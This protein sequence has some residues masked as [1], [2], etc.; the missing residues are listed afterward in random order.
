M[1]KV[2]NKDIIYAVV[3]IET[4]GGRANRDKITEIAIV[5]TNGREII[6][7]YSTLIN[8]ETFIPYEITRLTGIDQSMVADAPKFYEVAKEIVQFTENCLFIAHNVR[9]DYEFIREEFDRLG[10]SFSRNKACT[11]QLSRKSFPGLRSYSLGNLIEHFG[12][13]AKNRH[14]AYDDAKATAEL[15]HLILASGTM[16]ED[17]FSLKTANKEAVL[18]KDW[19]KKKVDAIP[20]DCGVYYFTNENGQIVYVGKSK[21]IRTRIWE[22]FAGINH[23]GLKLQQ[24]VS[25]IHWNLTST[26]LMAL[27]WELIEIKKHRPSLNKVARNS[28]LNVGV[29]EQ[30][31]QNGFLYFEIRKNWSESDPGFLRS[32]ITAARASSYIENVIHKFELC[33]HVSTG[34]KALGQCFDFGIGLCKGVCNGVES[35]EDYNSRAIA[36]IQHIKDALEG[37]WILY[38]VTPNETCIYY[39][40]ESGIFRGF[41]ELSYNEQFNESS[42]LEQ[43][44][45]VDY[46]SDYQKLMKQYF[47]KPWIK[48]IKIRAKDEVEHELISV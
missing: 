7:H 48:R 16:I 41:V 4:T 23:K 1:A 20:N 36:V 40:I 12:F 26:E 42:L 35:K 47:Y 19:T 32:F 25:D 18:P 24:H 22:H 15:L 43:M 27:V 2:N 8:P 34:R 46:H 5:R 11:V 29:Y 33:T 10:Y 21:H 45:L 39:W 38:E 13:N 28:K 17:P 6:D 30:V 3:D 37:S 31:D 9:F 44:N 14:R